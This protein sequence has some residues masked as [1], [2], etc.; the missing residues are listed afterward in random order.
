MTYR[1]RLQKIL[2]P[3]VGETSF[4]FPAAGERPDP[5]HSRLVKG[6]T[7]RPLPPKGPSS[8]KKSNYVGRLFTT[9]AGALALDPI[10]TRDLK[11]D[12]PS[13]SRPR[14]PGVVSAAARL[15]VVDSATEGGPSRRHPGAGPGGEADSAL[16]GCLRRCSRGAGG[17]M[18]GP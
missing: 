1:Q 17:A 2:G 14:G 3:L 10:L 7:L 15:A 5:D 4:Q 11:K 9:P 12:G 18:S 16:T 13:W 6:A 8:P